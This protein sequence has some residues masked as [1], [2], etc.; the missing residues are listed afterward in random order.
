MCSVPVEE[1]AAA[2]ALWLAELEDALEAAQRAVQ[3]LPITREQHVL[4]QELHVRIQAARSEVYALRLGRHLGQT[5][6][7]DPEWTE[8]NPWRPA[9]GTADQTP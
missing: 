9:L 3:L 8:K 7:L 1:P 2:R 5:I 4:A 6:E